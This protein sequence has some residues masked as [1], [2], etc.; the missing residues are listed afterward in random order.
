LRRRLASA[1]DVFSTS[2]GRQARR[3]RANH[4]TIVRR[5]GVGRMLSAP[6]ET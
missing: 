2:A 3:K 1:M 4:G 5:C 6:P